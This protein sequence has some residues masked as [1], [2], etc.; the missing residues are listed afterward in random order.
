MVMYDYG[1]NAILSKQ[2]KNMQAATICDVFHNIHK[3]LKSRGSDPKIYITENE[4]SSDLKEAMKKDK[5]DY[6]LAP[7]H[8]HRLNAAEW[9]IQT[10]KNHFISGFSTINPYFS[11]R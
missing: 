5:I 1:S 2:I 4:C 10:C 6:Q 8:M 11:I 3:I 9:E 7:P